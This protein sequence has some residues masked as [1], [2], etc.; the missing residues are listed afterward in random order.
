MKS[1]INL[2]SK[3]KFKINLKSGNLKNN[4]KTKIKNF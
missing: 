3:N 2:K 1:K 4:L